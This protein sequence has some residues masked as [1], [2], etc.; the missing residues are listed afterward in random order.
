MHAVEFFKGRLHAPEAAAGEDRPGCRGLFHLLQF[1]L[2]FAGH[3]SG[4]SGRQKQ[5]D[6][7]AKQ[8]F[9]RWPPYSLS[10]TNVNDAELMQ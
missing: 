8:V 6:Q 3:G 5:A 2:R 7:Y 10:A 9:H 4:C 1:S